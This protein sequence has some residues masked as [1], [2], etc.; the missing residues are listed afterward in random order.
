M[1]NADIEKLSAD[2]A[3]AVAA[4]GTSPW[5]VQP[6]CAPAGIASCRAVIEAERQPDLFSN[7]GGIRP[8]LVPAIPHMIDL[9][10]PGHLRRRKL[11]NAGLMANAVEEMLRWTSPV[12]NERGAVEMTTL[13]GDLS[14]VSF[15]SPLSEIRR[16]VLAANPD[17]AQS[18]PAGW[19]S[20]DPAMG[21]PQNGEQSGDLSGRQILRPHPRHHLLQ[22]PPQKWQYAVP[23]RRRKVE[24]RGDAVA[25]LRE[26]RVDHVPTP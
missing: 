17:D 11:V 10:D 25:H 24:P 2:Q 1:R 22:L 3:R 6:L 12:K 13:T 21:Q 8:G 18:W 5:L 19:S 14:G 15:D 16:R 23:A 7:A 4:I 9:D 26:F 20:D